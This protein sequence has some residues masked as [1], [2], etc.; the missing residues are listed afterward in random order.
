MKALF[1]EGTQFLPKPYTQN[2]L[3]GCVAAMLAA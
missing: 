1:V 3:E 2:Q